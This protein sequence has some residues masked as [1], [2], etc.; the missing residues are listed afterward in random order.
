MIKIEQ[1]GLDG[2]LHIKPYVFEDFRGHYV[3][4]Y[5]DKI[6]KEAGIDLKFIQDDVS[7]SSRNVLRG[8]HGDTVTHK[9]LSCLHGKIYF[10]VVNCDKGSDQFGRWQS[11]ILTDTAYNQV[12]VPPGYG[13][14]YFVLSDK[15]V[16]SYKQTTYYDRSKQFT[17]LWNDPK[18]NIF[19]PVDNPILS[20]RD[21][22]LEN[23]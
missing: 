22:G 2:V 3:E 21:K 4:T 16:F 12:L 20:A 10:V 23:D 7:V 5:N 8:I 6:Y 1:T 11:F 15:A 17:Y 19:W 9:L 18:F 13:N 14:G